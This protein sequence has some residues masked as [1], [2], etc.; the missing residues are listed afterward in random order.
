MTAPPARPYSAEYE[1][2]LTW[3]SLTES[4]LNWYGARPDPVRPRAWPKKVLL[5]SVPSTTMLFKVP[6]WPPKTRSPTRKLSLTTAGVE[7]TK[8]R[9]LRPLV[10]RALISFSS[11]TEVTSDLVVSIR[12]AS[13]DTVTAACTPA[14]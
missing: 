8:S 10:G 14:G 13:L 5:L 1:L 4:R 7:S 9:K 6:R 2:V 12:G 3:N 11:T